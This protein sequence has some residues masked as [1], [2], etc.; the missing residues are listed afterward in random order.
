MHNQIIIK[1]SA[2]WIEQNQEIELLVKQD[3]IQL[4]KSTTKQR[5][6]KLFKHRES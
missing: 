1:L 6:I 5:Y 2:N 3:I 4:T